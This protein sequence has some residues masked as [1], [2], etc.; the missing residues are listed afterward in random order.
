MIDLAPDVF[1]SVHR[2]AVCLLCPFRPLDG[3]ELCEQHRRLVNAMTV[4]LL[5]SPAGLAQRDL[6][7]LRELVDTEVVA[8]W[9]VTYLRTRQVIEQPVGSEVFAFVDPATPDGLASIVPSLRERWTGAACK[10]RWSRGVGT[11][12]LRC[13][14]CHA[15]ISQARGCT[16]AGFALA[17]AS[18]RV[19]WARHVDRG[20]TPRQHPQK[21]ARR[22]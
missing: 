14:G 12:A 1:P 3:D 5:R 10:P 20:W 21:A 19:L 7:E 6:T 2:A 13:D 9:A 22:R 11:L 8:L 16:S 18:A 4:G 15:W 17:E